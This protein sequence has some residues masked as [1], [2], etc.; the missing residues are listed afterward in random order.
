MKK[1]LITFQN[2]TFTYSDQ[3]IPVLNELNVSIN[4]GEKILVI[5]PSG[6]GKSTFARCLSGVLPNKD[7]ND[8]LGNIFIGEDNAKPFISN[9][10]PN[11]LAISMEESAVALHEKSRNL[12]SKP[13]VEPF[14]TYLGQKKLASMEWFLSKYPSLRNSNS[15]LSNH[16]FEKN[17]IG[18]FFRQ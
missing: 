6:S 7:N 17:K 15:R 2:F 16:Q 9:F 10:L 11:E 8:F 4:E 5:G 12:R 14:Q 13:A 1:P 3:T 18:R